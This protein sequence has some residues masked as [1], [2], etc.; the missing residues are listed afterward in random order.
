M[1]DKNLKKKSQSFHNTLCTHP[2]PIIPYFIIYFNPP[3]PPPPRHLLP[4]P[5]VLSIIIFNPPPL[6]CHAPNP[7]PAPPYSIV[8]I[9]PPSPPSPLVLPRVLSIFFL[10][11]Y[12]PISCPTFPHS[13]LVILFFLFFSSLS[14]SL[15]CPLTQ[16][17]R[18]LFLSATHPPPPHQS[19]RYTSLLTLSP[20]HPRPPLDRVI[21][22]FFFFLSFPKALTHSLPFFFTHPLSNPPFQR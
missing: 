3:P 4:S 6:S 2:P 18:T 20:A 8:H 5:R 17:F 16:S 11:L 7:H 9:I 19:I 14:L 15:H 22:S 21:L 12:P 1:T 10:I 13:Y